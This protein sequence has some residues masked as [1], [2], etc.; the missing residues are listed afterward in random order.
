MA[1]NK[2]KQ[3]HKK[4][5]LNDD[6]ADDEPAAGLAR[7]FIDEQYSHLLLHTLSGSSA[8]DLARVAGVGLPPRPPAVTHE[9]LKRRSAATRTMWSLRP[10]ACSSCFVKPSTV[11]L[12]DQPYLYLAEVVGLST[13]SS[14]GRGDSLL[15][16][17][18][19]FDACMY[20]ERRCLLFKM[21][22]S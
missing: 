6:K 14:R 15:S 11:S 2:K 12:Q 16:S 8:G 22:T 5:K 21:V 1:K 13:A 19:K 17:Q 7:L 20:F 9:M 3:Q 10:A 18:A 4:P